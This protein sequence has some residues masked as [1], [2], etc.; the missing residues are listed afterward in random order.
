MT[1]QALLDRLAG[2]L[3]GFAAYWD[4]PGNCFRDD[5][6]SFTSLGV[7]AV[8]YSYFQEHGEQLPPDRLAALGALVSECMASADDELATA[9]ATGFLEGARFKPAFVRH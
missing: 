3:P 9:A 5:D 8:L 4:D 6:G 1:P 2:V 7:F